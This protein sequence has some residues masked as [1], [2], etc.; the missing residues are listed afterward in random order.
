MIVRDFSRER[1]MERLQEAA[2][3]SRLLCNLADYRGL[4]DAPTGWRRTVERLPTTRES[5]LADPRACNCARLC[6]RTGHD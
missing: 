2:R 3:K 5:P 6:A 4:D 1:S